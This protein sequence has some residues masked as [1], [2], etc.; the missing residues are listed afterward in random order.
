MK[1]IK[2]TL[3]TTFLLS[4][5]LL[6]FPFDNNSANRIAIHSGKLVQVQSPTQPNQQAPNPPTTPPP[7]PHPGPDPRPPK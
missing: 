7:A 2:S 5:S 1:M 6:Y 4:L 3:V